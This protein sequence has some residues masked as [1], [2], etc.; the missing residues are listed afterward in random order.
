[1]ADKPIDYLYLWE[2]I[3]W[4][5][6]NPALAAV[7]TNIPLAA[8]NAATHRRLVRLYL[9]FSRINADFSFISILTPTEHSG[10]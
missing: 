4:A 6:S 10:A 8:S 5:N 3:M 7:N 1:M 2:A 9:I